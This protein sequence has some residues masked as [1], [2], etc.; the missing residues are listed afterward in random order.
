MELCQK[1]LQIQHLCSSIFQ[2]RLGYFTNALKCV[3]CM[4]V[5]TIPSWIPKLK[6]PNIFFNLPPPTYQ[7]ITKIIKCMKFSGS[8]CPLDQIA[9]I[10]FKRCPYLRPFISNICTEVLRSNTLPTQW[11]KAATILI[12]KTGDPS[13][14]E[15]FRPINF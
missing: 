9:I 5:F 12:H 8:S 4:K 13:L 3:Y 2:R 14:P 7:K 1:S 11:T 15:N 6:E 10:C